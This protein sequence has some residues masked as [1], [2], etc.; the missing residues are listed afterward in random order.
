MLNLTSYVDKLRM[1]RK[2]DVHENQIKFS[3]HKSESR[4]FPTSRVSPQTKLRNLI[5]AAVTE[6]SDETSVSH[7]PVDR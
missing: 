7:L 3:F 4:T 6:P 1:P 2:K 5:D